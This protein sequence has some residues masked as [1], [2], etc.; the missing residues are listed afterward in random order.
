MRWASLRAKNHR[1]MPST[2]ALLSGAQKW[3]HQ[4]EVVLGWLMNA[5]INVHVPMHLRTTMEFIA[6]LNPSET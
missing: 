2:N 3:H 1:L 4:A 6:K 5:H